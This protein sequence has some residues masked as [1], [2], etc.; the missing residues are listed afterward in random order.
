MDRSRSRSSMAKTTEMGRERENGRPPAADAQQGVTAG[1][2]QHGRSRHW[3]ISDKDKDF[4]RV[5][6]HKGNMGCRQNADMKWKKQKD[7]Y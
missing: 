3:E 6:H 1:W 5:G 2:Q 4:V 7:G